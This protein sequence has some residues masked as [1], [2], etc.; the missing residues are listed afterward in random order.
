[1]ERTTTNNLK[2]KNMVEKPCKEIAADIISLTASIT[3]NLVRSV[4]R[5]IFTEDE[6]VNAL[7]AKLGISRELAEKIIR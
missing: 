1:M 2:E 4:S 6:A 5:G 7:V 3:A